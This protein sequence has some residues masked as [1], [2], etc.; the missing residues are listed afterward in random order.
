MN[1]KII[2]TAFGLAA[3]AATPAF[4][5]KPAHGASAV[6]YVSAAA[7]VFSEG[8]F[9]GTDPD[10]SIRSELSRD[11]STYTTTN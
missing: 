1:T 10:P 11:S 9:A 6:P 3:L 4:A 7:P 2:L 5:Q 8:R